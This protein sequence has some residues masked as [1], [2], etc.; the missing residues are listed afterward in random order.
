M[1]VDTIAIIRALGMFFSGFF[2]SSDN[3]TI[4]AKPIKEKNIN[5]AAE[6]TPSIE[7]ISK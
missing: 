7:G 6:K 4:S 1:V 2:V 3:R 5:P